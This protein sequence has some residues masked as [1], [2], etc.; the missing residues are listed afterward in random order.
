[1]ARL[2]FTTR[3]ITLGEAVGEAYGELQNLRDEAQ[4]M[5]DN[6]T[7]GLQ[8]TQRLQTMQESA[9][10]LGNNCDSEPE[11][12]EAVAK[13]PFTITDWTNTRKGR[14]LSRT[15]RC[16]WAVHVLEQ[17][18]ELLDKMVDDT[19]KLP[20]GVDKDAVEGARDDIEN[21]KT[22]AEGTEWPGMY[23]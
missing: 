11:L 20:A 17:A 6:A 10:A 13:L 15:D 5:Y 9:D 7:E 16:S 14:G 21:M 1:M 3:N 23:G 2:K 19:T 4:E 12:P 18:Y 8:Q 22:D